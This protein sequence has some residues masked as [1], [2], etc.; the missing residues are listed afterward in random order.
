MMANVGSHDA[1]PNDWPG[2][3]VV[4]DG[5]ATLSPNSELRTDYKE[6]R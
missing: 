4:S 5:H 2:L 1:V 3:Q 6:G